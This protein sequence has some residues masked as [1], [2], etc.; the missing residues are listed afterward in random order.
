MFSINRLRPVLVFAIDAE[1]G[2]SAAVIV[3]INASKVI[4]VPFEETFLMPVV[5]IMGVINGMDIPGY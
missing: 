2:M 5:A 3:V 4:E 1:D